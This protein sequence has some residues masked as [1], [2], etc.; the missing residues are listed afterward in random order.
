MLR[1]FKACCS[2][3]LTLIPLIVTSVGCDSFPFIVSDLSAQLTARYE[4][5]NVLVLD[6]DT[7]EPIKK[8]RVRGPY[9][10]GAM[11]RDSGWTD[12]KGRIRLRA[13]CHSENPKFTAEAEGYL[14]GELYT[15]TVSRNGK[16]VT[17][18][19]YRPPAPLIGITIPN[20][21]RGVIEVQFAGG[22]TPWPTHRTWTPGQREFYTPIEIDGVTVLLASP[23]PRGIEREGAGGVWIVRFDDGTPLRYENPISGQGWAG[24]YLFGLP[25][26][27][28]MVPP[29]TDGVAFFN[30]GF[31]AEGPGPPFNG[32]QMYF[33]GT[34]DEAA[35]TQQAEIRGSVPLLPGKSPV[36]GQYTFKARPLSIDE[37]PVGTQLSPRWAG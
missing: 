20:G 34:K 4:H 23:I 10:G 2:Y 15:G 26:I 18:E 28:N 25:D 14:W 1:G 32:Y 37:L 7:A 9:T 8:A 16:D 31:K 35:T 13:S 27:R 17:I 29:R 11:S 21:F 36:A 5:Y 33:V 22:N 3:P 6:G 19:L 30:L 12:S 24:E